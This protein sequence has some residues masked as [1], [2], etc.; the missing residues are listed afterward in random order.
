VGAPLRIVKGWVA[1]S[2]ESMARFALKT[3]M[4]SPG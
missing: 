2:V 3:I 1:L 4:Y